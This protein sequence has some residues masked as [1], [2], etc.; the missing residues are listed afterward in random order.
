[1]D[2]SECDPRSKYLEVL[3]ATAT[4]T[5]TV[6]TAT[7]TRVLILDHPRREGKGREGKGPT[8]LGLGL[9]IGIGRLFVPSKSRVTRGVV[10]ASSWELRAGARSGSWKGRVQ[11]CE[12]ASH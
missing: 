8:R 12:D 2:V 6:I 7:A 10:C 11:R 3:L 5:A 4:S 1:M 9:G